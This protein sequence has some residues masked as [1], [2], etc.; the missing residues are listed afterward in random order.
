MSVLQSVSVCKN[1]VIK[2]E[3]LR[4]VFGSKNNQV[5]ALKSISVGIERG[6][7]TAIMGP[8]GSGKSTFMHCVAGLDRVTDGL[9]KLGDQEI[10]GLSERKLTKFRREKIGFV[11]QS[12]NLIPT[13]TAAENIRL[14]MEIAHKKIDEDFYQLVVKALDLGDRLGHKPAELSGGQQQRVACARALLQ[15]PQVLFA[16]EPTGNLDSAASEQVLRFLRQCVDDFGQTVVMVTHEP[17]SAAW[18]DRVLFLKDGELI[19]QLDRP[20]QGTI[21]RGLEE[22]SAEKG[23]P[24]SEHTLKGN[25]LSLSETIAPVPVPVFP[26]KP[27]SNPASST[28]GQTAKPVSDTPE[29][30]LAGSSQTTNTGGIVVTKYPSRRSRTGGIPVISPISTGSIPIINQSSDAKANHKMSGKWHKVASE[31]PDDRGYPPRRGSHAR[32]SET[33]EQN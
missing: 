28:S 27:V 32:C 10:S 18:A 29:K 5:V 25:G 4:K 24:R 12:F 2:V 17:E 16:D 13:L 3:N 33:T 7:L 31:L 20:N 30:R 22:L 14:P 21:L 9:V 1:P 19:A 6:A 26:A 23:I 11:F 15:K 8:S